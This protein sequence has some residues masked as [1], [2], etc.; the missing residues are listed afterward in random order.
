MLSVV[1]LCGPDWVL[2]AADSSVS[3]SII[4]MSEE[5]D[6]IVEVDKRNA[7]AMAGETGD[8]LQL[9]EYIQGNVAL[10]KYRNGIELSTEAMSHYIRSIMAEA[11]RKNP[12]EVNMLLG[13]YDGKPSLYYMDYLGTLQKIPFGAQGYCSY[14]VL[15]VFDKY[16]KPDMTLDEGKELMKKALDQIKQRFTIA[17]HGFIVKQIDANGIQKITIN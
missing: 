13:G 10:Y 7:L 15:S 1:G 12:Y 3:S 14:F 6:R 2:I 9:S 4:C 5:Y 8:S 17:P 11:I 16:Y